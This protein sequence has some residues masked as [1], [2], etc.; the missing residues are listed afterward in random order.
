MPMD[1]VTTLPAIDR[2][3]I[4]SHNRQDMPDYVA[5]LP[6]DVSTHGRHKLRVVNEAVIIGV[7]HT[8]NVINNIGQLHV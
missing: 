7:V 6:G 2:V 5:T 3:R 4:T 8:Q 1:Y